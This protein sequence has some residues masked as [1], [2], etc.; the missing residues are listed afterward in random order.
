MHKLF[1][2]MFLLEQ[3][4]SKFIFYGGFFGAEKLAVTYAQIQS[5]ITDHLKSCLW[6]PE[7]LFQCSLSC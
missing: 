5:N 3:T 1:D 2:H 7:E 4:N 6:T